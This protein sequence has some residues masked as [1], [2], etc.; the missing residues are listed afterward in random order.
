[1]ALNPVVY[2][3]KVLLSFLR[4]Q[5]TAYRFEDGRLR[6]QMRELLSLD[7]TRRSP[8]MQGPYVSLSRPFRQGAAV[9]ELI[10]DGLFHPH[11]RQRIP[12]EITHVYG[13]RMRL[14]NVGASNQISDSDSIRGGGQRRQA[15]RLV[16]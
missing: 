3:E 16:R 10:A 9:D 7:E 12:P 8:L 11:M 6:S 15:E 2:T 14:V 13:V 4:Y 5:I 1:M